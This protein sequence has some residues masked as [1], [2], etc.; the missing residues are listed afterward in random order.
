MLPRSQGMCFIGKQ[1]VRWIEPVSQRGP[2][3][4]SARQCAKP[5][6][7]VLYCWAGAASLPGLTD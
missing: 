6:C 1:Q 2:G 5:G 7:F 4:A 3:H